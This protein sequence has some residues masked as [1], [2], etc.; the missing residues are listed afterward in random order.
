MD[1][2]RRDAGAETP[3]IMNDPAFETNTRGHRRSIDDPDTCRICRGEGTEDEPLFYPCRCSGSIKY[4]H[5]ECLMEWLSHSQK[6][7]CELC[8]TPFRFTKLYHPQMPQGLPTTVFIKQAIFDCFRTLLIWS[9]Y[10]LVGFVWLFWLP[11]TMRTVWRGLFWLGDGGWTL[12]QPQTSN[13]ITAKQAVEISRQHLAEALAARGQTSL[14][15]DGYSTPFPSSTLSAA[16]ALPS[17]LDPISVSLNMSAKETTFFSLVR[18]FFL[19]FTF[20]GSKQSPFAGLN[21]SSLNVSAGLETPLQKQS[22]LSEVQ[23]LQNLTRFPAL[24]RL[25]I[26]ILEGQ[27]ITVFVVATFIL[28]FLIRE[29]VVQQQ[30]ALNLD[31][32]LN[33]DVVVPPGD[34]EGDDEAGAGIEGDIRRHQAALQQAQQILERLRQN[35]D[36]AAGDLPEN[37]PLQDVVEEAS[38]NPSIDGPQRRDG[39]DSDEVLPARQ[40]Q[41]RHANLESD[42]DWQARL[43]Q[44]LGESLH[45]YRTDS[46]SNG[47]PLSRQ[48]P[49]M[50][51]RNALSRATEIQRTIEERNRFANTPEMERSGL[52]VFLDVWRRAEGDPEELLRILEDTD[53]ASLGWVSETMRQLRDSDTPLDESFKDKLWEF[54]D[55]FA[56]GKHRRQAENEATADETQDEAPDNHDNNDTFGS[57]LENESAEAPNEVSDAAYFGEEEQQELNED[58]LNAFGGVRQEKGKSRL[59]DTSDADDHISPLAASVQQSEAFVDNQEEQSQAIPARN[60]LETTGMDDLSSDRAASE[61]GHDR[62]ASQDDHQANVQFSSSAQENT[63]GHVTH[64][65]NA[66]IAAPGEPAAGNGNRETPPG[67]P[68]ENALN[69]RDG[70]VERLIDG[71]W[72]GVPIENARQEAPRGDD[73]HVVENIENEAPFVPVDRAQG[74]V[75]EEENADAD[76]NLDPNDIQAVE[77]ADDF[78][79]LLELIGIQGPL[80]VLFQNALFSAVFIS[81]TVGG[82]VWLPYIW[83]KIVLFLLGNP[84]SVLFKLPLQLI[85]FSADL[86]ADLFLFIGGSFVYW[87][88][89]ASRFALLPLTLV[90]PFISRLTQNTKVATVSRSIAEG[91]LERMAKMAADASVGFSENDF[92]AF[93]VLSHEALL[94]LKANVTGAFYLS[95]QLLLSILQGLLAPAQ[96]ISSKAPDS[97]VA[98]GLE[99][100]LRFY[101][102]EAARLLSSIPTLFTSNVFK[103]TLEVGNPEKPF[104]PE[105]AYWNA[106]DRVIAIFAGYMFFFVVGALYLRR[107]K[108]FSTSEQGRKFEQVLCEIL[109]QA[110][111][112]MKVILIISI[113]MIL[114]PLYCGM[115][116]DIA[117]LPLFETAT[118]ASRLEF[119]MNSPWTS[120]F[121]HWFLGTCYMFHFALFVSMCRKIMR[122]GVLYFIRDPDDPTFH[123]V[124]DVLERNVSTQLRK[125]AFSALVYGALVIVCLGGIVWSLYAA[126]DGILPIYWSSSEPVLEFPVDL[127]FYNFLMPLAVGFFRPSDGLNRLYSWWFR[128]CA[129]L[130]R[131]TQFFFNERRRD[132]EGRR[133]LSWWADIFSRRNDAEPTPGDERDKASGE[134]ERAPESQRQPTGL[135]RDGRYVR[136]PASDQVR[137]PKGNPVF[138]EVNENNERVDGLPDPDDGLHG[139]N[140]G[141]FTQVYIPPWFRIRIAAFLLLLWSFAAVTGVGVTVIPLVVGRMIFGLMVP[142]HR[143]MNDIYAFSLGIYVVGGI[144]YGVLHYKS[145]IDAIKRSISLQ[146]ESAQAI[147]PRLQAYIMRLARIAY[148]YTAFGLVLPSLFALLMEFYIIVPL[149]TYLASDEVHVIH[150]MQDWTLGVLYVKISGRLI[151]WYSQSRPAAALRAI[152]RRGWLDPD[153]SI[154]TRCFILPAVVVMNAA[155]FLPLPL[156]YLANRMLFHDADQ[157]IQSQVYRYSYPA[158]LFLCLWVVCGYALGHLVKGWRQRIK[159]DVYLI[160][161]RLHNF[162]ERRGPL[163]TPG[164]RVQT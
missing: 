44:S 69:R 2:A 30:P 127:L 159:D 32:P 139:K 115:L 74:P 60:T 97:S 149:H 113:E 46:A 142:G 26:R 105:L 27:I 125:I 17:I 104:D 4:V 64:D 131:L 55:D 108:P 129:R 114:F 87:T 19:D 18:R 7:Y 150:F 34:A 112:I 79:G 15:Q 40:P 52:R 63:T 66:Q 83:G 37:A 89:A 145:T 162:G 152:V 106:K 41:S 73:E 137:I 21:S 111:G 144:M 8:K 16:N 156:G 25:A 54:L 45:L 58:I 94:S 155:L 157:A 163:A 80:V 128:K 147:S 62:H 126:F 121:V 6:K 82:G 72:G 10:F 132:E 77:E 22:L 84:I 116:L 102:E 12:W 76:A 36:L 65:V 86:V 160:G 68:E 9:R 91:G 53:D 100:N 56:N 109:A 148:T 31:V 134:D 92:P 13:P 51:T 61:N 14:T 141:L 90:F 146:S 47:G 3:D 117:L 50:P 107:G 85:L 136:A 20:D 67:G 57:L 35:D 122:S 59:T 43:E 99:T 101:V 98:A 78:D 124:R 38:S 154:A 151:L 118:L 71:L 5:Q 96:L 135:I 143:R 158:V 138:L 140:T 93:S 39:L 42:T 164:A 49:G 29:W 123:P 11:W 1:F 153:A 161:E 48:R 33:V 81:A 103:V 23:F 130:L 70:L 24:N 110:G 95:Y 28:I 75:G 88:T 120:G 133:G 119:A